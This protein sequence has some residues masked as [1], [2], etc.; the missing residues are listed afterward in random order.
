MSARNKDPR[1]TLLPD[2]GAMVDEQGRPPGAPSR[3]GPGDGPS[4]DPTRVDRA[5]AREKHEKTGERP[6][7]DGS[8]GQPVPH[9]ADEVP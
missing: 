1:E 7:A 2:Q 8:N 9:A 3:T 5:R 6:L 4:V